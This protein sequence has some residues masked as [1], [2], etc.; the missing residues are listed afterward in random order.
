[1]PEEGEAED[2]QARSLPRLRADEVVPT[3]GDEAPGVFPVGHCTRVIT[4][5]S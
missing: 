2:R 3:E 5:H 4:R 1:M